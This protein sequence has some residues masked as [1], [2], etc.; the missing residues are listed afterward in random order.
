MQDKIFIGLVGEAGSGKDTVAKRLKKK[1]QAKILTSSYLLKKALKVFLEEIGRG[2]YIWF[3]KALTKKY[4]EDII[5][6]AM[7]KSMHEYQGKI[8]V[9]NGV[10]LP[11]DYKYLRREHSY[12]IYITA[13]AKIRWE[14][15]SKRGEKCDD[16]ASFEE[17][18][19]MH[20]EKTEVNVPEI[21][22][23][24]DYFIK[25][26]GTLE[27]LWEKTDKIMAKIIKDHS[28]GN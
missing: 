22:K 24:A 28:G 18:M 23:K 12:L 7:L 16:A 15:T 9:F 3:V 20:Q 21:G 26:N 11:S 25:N 8:I 6:R 13:G 27:D 19:A 4:G 5:S 17:F 1:H 10:R 14:R 2:D